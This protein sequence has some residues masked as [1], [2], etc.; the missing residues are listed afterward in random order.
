MSTSHDKVKDVT[1]T[2]SVVFYRMIRCHL[3]DEGFGVL[4]VAL[5]DNCHKLEVLM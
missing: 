4:A 5:S 3:T 1:L 2:A